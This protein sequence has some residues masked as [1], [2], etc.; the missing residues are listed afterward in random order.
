MTAPARNAPCPCGSGRKYKNCCG[1]LGGSSREDAAALERAVELRPFDAEAHY[2]LALAREL[3]GRLEDALASH[4]RALRARPGF[5]AAH[6]AALRA[7][8]KLVVADPSRFLGPTLGGEDSQPAP[9][10]ASLSI[11]ICSIDSAKFAAVTANYRS[12]LARR[13]HEIIGIH[14]A[15]SLCEGYNRGA[16]Q[17]SGDIVVFSHDDV[18]ILSVDFAARLTRALAQHALVGVAGTTH[19]PVEGWGRPGWPY[20]HGQIAHRVPGGA[21]YAVDVFGVGGAIVPGVQAVDGVFFAVRREVL[22]AVRFDETTFDGFHFYDIDFSYRVFRA[23]FEVAVSNEIAI[24]HHSRGHLGDEWR[25]YA[26]RFMAKHATDVAAPSIA[27]CYWGRGEAQ[28][29][30]AEQVVAFLSAT[31]SIAGAALAARPRDSSP[32]YDSSANSTSAIRAGA[33]PGFDDAR[34]K[35]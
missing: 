26:E 32:R 12:L 34:R 8:G 22:D 1:A 24:V 5:E 9:G 31:V 6:Q 29:Y 10:A 21:R 35:R 25:R 7:L 16:A 33:I 30:T 27:P 20:R 13:P 19:F 23:G 2:R 28:L 17:A 11:V 3:Q 14:D 4:E 18:E 15:K